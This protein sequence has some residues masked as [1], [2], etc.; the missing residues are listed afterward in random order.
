MQVPREADHALIAASNQPDVPL[1]AFRASQL[2]AP[3]ASPLSPPSPSSPPQSSAAVVAA[4]ALPA[5][6]EPAPHTAQAVGE[7]GTSLAPLDLAVE[8]QTSAQAVAPA[9]QLARARLLQDYLTS[10]EAQA[11]RRAPALFWRHPGTPWWLA[12]QQLL[13]RSACRVCP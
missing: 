6:G 12:A 4:T 8:P 5:P 1:A 11:R 2:Q 10:Y 13:R 7:T 9:E 3:P